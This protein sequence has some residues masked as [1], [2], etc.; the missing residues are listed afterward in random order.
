MTHKRLFVVALLAVLSAGCL[1]KCGRKTGLNPTGPSPVT[2]PPP[3][4][5]GPM[6]GTDPI[7]IPVPGADAIFRFWIESLDPPIGGTYVEGVTMATVSWACTAPTLVIRY[8]MTMT[9][10]SGPGTPEFGNS[11]NGGSGAS[12]GLCSGYRHGASITIQNRG[13]P[14]PYVRLKIWL[15]KQAA[16]GNPDGVVDQP[17]NWTVQ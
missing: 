15:N 16:D 3:N 8:Y 11:F 1:D 2:P 9:F 6:P 7:N 12:G 14:I 17:V 4:S 5:I 10:S 13:R